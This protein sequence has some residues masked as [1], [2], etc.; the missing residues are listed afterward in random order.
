[1]SEL[2]REIDELKEARAEKEK[3]EAHAPVASKAEY[4]PSGAGDA[5][6]DKAEVIRLRKQVTAME[7][8]LADY[9]MVGYCAIWK[10]VFAPHLFYDVDLGRR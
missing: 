6:R 10:T 3:E 5:A 9:G 8:F 2:Q 7:R 1:M 4:A